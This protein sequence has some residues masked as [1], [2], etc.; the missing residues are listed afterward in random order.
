MSLDSQNTT[1]RR[2]PF[3]VNRRPAGDYA[4]QKFEGGR[5]IRWGVYPTEPHAQLQA[6]IANQYFSDKK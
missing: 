2:T 1:P 4:V 6:Q 3:R 5:I